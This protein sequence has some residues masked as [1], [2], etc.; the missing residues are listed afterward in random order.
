MEKVVAYKKGSN[1]YWVGGW[2]I[3][4]KSRLLSQNLLHLH[5]VQVDIIPVQY[6][7]AMVVMQ[8]AIYRA[9]DCFDLP[10]HWATNTTTRKTV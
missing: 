5:K 9:L 1:E 2:V 3:S 4:P 10:T 7:V 6:V 8:H